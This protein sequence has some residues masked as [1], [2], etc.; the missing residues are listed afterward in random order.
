[1]AG[2]GSPVVDAAN[3]TIDALLTYLKRRR[4]LW[5]LHLATATTTPN[6]QSMGV[7]L[8]GDTGV[9]TAQSIIG[10]VAV[11]ARVVVV[12]VP[13]AGYYIAGYVGNSPA[14]AAWLPYTPTTSGLTLGSPG[15]SL[16]TRYK[17]EGHTVDYRGRLTLGTGGLF[18]ST[19][20]ISLPVAA[21]DANYTGSA[22]AFVG[23]AAQRQP[24]VVT[25][26]GTTNINFY[27]TGGVVNATVPATW[28][29]GNVLVWSVRYEV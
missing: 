11:G 21:L 8:D 27:A 26:S 20:V 3:T 4:M 9:T 19:L 16:V 23:T 25:P 12:Y 15:G 2:K 10:P 7:T 13:P 24:A 22:W 29:A 17:Q 18:T 28:A 1:M 6:G 14:Q 5:E